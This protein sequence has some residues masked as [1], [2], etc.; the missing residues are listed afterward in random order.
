MCEIAFHTA[1]QATVVGALLRTM[2]PNHKAQLTKCSF[3][4]MEN[5]AEKTHMST[6]QC[7]MISVLLSLTAPCFPSGTCS[8]CLDVW[9]TMMDHMNPEMPQPQDP[10]RP[11]AHV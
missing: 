1:A 3:L 7:G 5:R 10:P 6:Q 8:N 9:D 11:L 2:E 4:P